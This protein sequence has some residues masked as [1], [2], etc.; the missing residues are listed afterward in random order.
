MSSY[1]VCPQGVLI[2]EML[3]GVA[4]F[5]AEDPMSTYE[6]VLASKVQ[7]PPFFS[8]VKKHSYLT[9]MIDSTCIL[10]RLLVLCSDV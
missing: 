10:W 9:P 2:Y 1:L 4:P 5:Y 3:A 7:P 6:N 8:K